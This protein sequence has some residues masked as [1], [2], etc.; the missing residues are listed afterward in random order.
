MAFSIIPRFNAPRGAKRIR[1]EP[2]INLCIFDQDVRQIKNSNMLVFTGTYQIYIPLF[3][4]WGVFTHPSS[5]ATLRDVLFSIYADSV[6]QENGTPPITP[7][8]ILTHHPQMAKIFLA[9]MLYVN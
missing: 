6:Q 3:E 9:S 7:K 2:M 1:I 5:K 4:Y 8:T